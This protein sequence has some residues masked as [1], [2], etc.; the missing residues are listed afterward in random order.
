[1]CQQNTL[2]HT[3]VLYI[4][5]PLLPF[6]AA[7]NV[8]AEKRSTAVGI[9]TAA[10][11]AGTALAFGISPLLISKFG[12]QWV[13]YL[14]G[15]SALLWLPFWLPLNVAR[16]PPGDAISGRS[17]SWLP[18]QQQQQQQLPSRSRMSAEEVQPLLPPAAGEASGTD[19]QQAQ[20]QAT[21]TPKAD[22]AG[23]DSPAALVASSSNSDN[24][25]SSSS[26]SSNT[27]FWAL[28]RRREVWA[29][30]A[31]QYAQ[32]YGMYGLL[33]WLPT[34]FSDYY[35]VQVGDLGGYT[36]LPYLLQVRT[37]GLCCLGVFTAAAASLVLSADHVDSSAN[38]KP[39][40]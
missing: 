29:I 33:T 1:M 34:F 26:S 4:L 16:Q 39:T 6:A 30:C 18:A 19:L 12:W 32:S 40:C 15:G 8:P 9:V 7:R 3:T 17:A 27:G 20:Q 22:A 25:S 38:P 13:F 23:G 2:I 21:G 37:P 24:L 10:S 36:L 14:F 35:E 28:M 11:Y 31:C 5:L